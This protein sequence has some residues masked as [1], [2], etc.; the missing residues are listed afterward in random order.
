MTAAYAL[1]NT[2]LH[3]HSPGF[4]KIKVMCICVNIYQAFR[5]TKISNLTWVSKKK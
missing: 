1:M 5:N 3:I 2:L 4:S